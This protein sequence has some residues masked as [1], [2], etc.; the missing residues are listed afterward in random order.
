MFIKK[1]VPEFGP[2]LP[3]PSVFTDPK[4]LRRFL[5]V[6]R[7]GQPAGEGSAASSA[8][9]DAC[10]APAPSPLPPCCSGTVM[11]GEKAALASPLA[12]FAKKK[13]RTLQALIDDISSTARRK[14]SCC[15]CLHGSRRSVCS[16]GKASGT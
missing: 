8:V 16:Q 13:A 2:A 9:C 10:P 3:N 11:N 5:I 1:S 4:E 6:K 14:P 7:T 15:C 12:T